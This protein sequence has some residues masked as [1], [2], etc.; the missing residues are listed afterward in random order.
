VKVVIAGG[1]GSLG[2]RIS[3]DLTDR[4]HQVVVLSRQ[5]ETNSPM[6]QVFWDGRTVG[7]WAAELEG[8]DTAVINLAGKLVDCRPTLDAALTDLIG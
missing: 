7:D 8:P 6:R 3:G 4:G 2:R 1:S 5:P